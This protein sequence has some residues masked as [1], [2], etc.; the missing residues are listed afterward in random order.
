[1]AEGFIFEFF[2]LEKGGSY[3]IRRLISSFS[4]SL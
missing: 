2:F 3:E 4:Y 1:V